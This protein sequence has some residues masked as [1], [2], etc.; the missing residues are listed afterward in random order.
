MDNSLSQAEIDALLKGISTSDID[1]DIKPDKEEGL[2]SE[3]IDAI[4]E[5]GNISIGTS[6]TTL[7]TLLN[8]KVIIT[9]PKVITTNWEQLSKEH[10]L[11]Y[12]AVTVKYTSG[13]EGAS[14]LI[15]KEDDVKIITNLM[16]GGDGKIEEGELNEMHLS[17]ISE[18]MNQMIGSAA[19]SLSSMLNKRINISP[20]TA[21]IIR[22]EN[23]EAYE[24]FADEALVKIAFKMV[25]GNL[26]DSEI[27]QLMPL[28][29]AKTLIQGVFENSMK[30]V[31]ETQQYQVK[32]EQPKQNVEQKD[33]T[34][35]F[36]MNNMRP[37]REE[38]SGNLNYQQEKI[39]QETIKVQPVQFK[40]F[41][42][43]N[44]V[45]EKQ[46]V[47][48][49][50]IVMDIPLEVTVELGRTRKIIKDILNFNNGTVIEL[51]KLAGDPVDIY[52]NEKKIA[53]GEVVVIDDS[54]GVRITDI[55]HPS[56]RV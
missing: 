39:P 6:A 23:T 22:F 48:N 8:Q 15:L 3:E 53:K 12:V 52:V 10:P 32:K 33:D 19:T 18:A 21:F 1:N 35:H 27:M 16:M 2:S 47:E 37:D 26:I 36:I 34:G 46:K 20:P 49:I 56:K 17:A 45:A 42:E 13:L 31:K 25:V 5:I 40:S 30:T 28:S 24:D 29:F 11:P 51:D 50:D 54:F 14:L 55:V 4:G 38:A 7:F 44:A 9:T 41:E 43:E